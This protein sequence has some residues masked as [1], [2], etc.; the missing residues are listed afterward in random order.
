MGHLSGDPSGK[1]EPGSSTGLNQAFEVEVQ[2]FQA[3]DGARKRHQ[4]QTLHENAKKTVGVEE[5]GMCPESDT[6]H[7]WL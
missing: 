2:S 7:Q 6:G 5:P 4:S 3:G 1:M